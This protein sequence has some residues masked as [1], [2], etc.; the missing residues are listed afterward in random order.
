MPVQRVVAVDDEESI[1]KIV[2]YALEQ[3]GFEV[4]TAGDATGGAFLIQEVHPDLLILDVML[5]GQERPRPRARHPPDLQRADHH[6]VGARR[7][8]RPHPRASSSAPTTT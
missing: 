7:R 1:L 4:H 2:R 3:E 6:A 5:P 8:G